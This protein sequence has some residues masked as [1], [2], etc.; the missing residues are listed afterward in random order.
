LRKDSLQFEANLGYL[1]RGTGR[2]QGGR[3]EQPPEYS[4]EK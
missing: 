4:L 1:V 2:R 3:K